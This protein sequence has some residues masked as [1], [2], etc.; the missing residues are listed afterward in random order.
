M[1]LI[2]TLMVLVEPVNGVDDLLNAV[3][4][5]LLYG[6]TFPARLDG[7]DLTSTSIFLTCTG[8]FIYF[9]RDINEWVGDF[10]IR[11]PQIGD[12][13]TRFSLLGKGEYTGFVV[14]AVGAVG[15]ATENPKLQK[16]FWLSLESIALSSIYSNVAKFLLGRERPYLN[17]EGRF[18]GPLYG[19]KGS[20][21]RSF[22]SGHAALA[23]SVGTVIAEQYNDNLGVKVLVY[24]L[25]SGVALSRVI[26]NKHHL[27]DVIVGS[28]LGFATAKMV[29]SLH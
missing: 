29:M 19:F 2:I 17:P 4:H 13:C 7:K 6:T 28:T 8:L 18:R 25:A 22:P 20:E 9:D 23:F 12:F 3:P 10:S 26:E 11:N 16:T 15:Y 21:Y 1:N 14:A 5:D 24:A 27:S